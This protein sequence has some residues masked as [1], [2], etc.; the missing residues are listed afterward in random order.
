MDVEALFITETLFLADEALLTTETLLLAAEVLLTTETLLLAVEARGG[1]EGWPTAEAWLRSADHVDG[2][3]EG[4]LAGVDTLSQALGCD[5]PRGALLA[6]GVG[7]VVCD[8]CAGFFTHVSL[9]AR[10]AIHKVSYNPG[11]QTT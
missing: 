4:G 10:V 9:E 8:V 6:D 5:S 3:S 7:V 11:G 2:S 1:C